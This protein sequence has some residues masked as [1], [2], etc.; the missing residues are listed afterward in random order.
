MPGEKAL[1]GAPL[2]PKEGASISPEQTSSR[3]AQQTNTLM[4]LI[5]A[6][7]NLSVAS[8]VSRVWL[9]EGLGSIPKRVQERML[10]WEFMDMA[11]FAPGQ[12]QIQPP[13][14]QIQKN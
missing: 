1:M 11:D 3:V 4:S 14:K 13:W 12:Q 8:K 5:S 9:G 7:K 6:H 2:F 10:R